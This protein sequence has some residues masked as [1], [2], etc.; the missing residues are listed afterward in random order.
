M[1]AP[2]CVVVP[3]SGADPA[4]SDAL[5]CYLAV[6]VT[7]PLAPATLRAIRADLGGFRAWWEQTHPSFDPTH[8]ARRDLL[9][10]RSERQT[11]G[12]AAPATINRGLSSLRGFCAWA[13]SVGRM[14]ED[15]TRGLEDVPSDPPAPRSL[16]T[17]AVDALLRAAHG[18]RDPAL[19][20]R[21]EAL[22]AVLV[23]AGLRAQEACDLQVRDLDLDGGTLTIRRGKGGKPRRVPLHPDAQH[24][25]QRYMTDVRCPDGP[26]LL[27][28]EA[29][30]TPLLVGR[31][32]TLPGQPLQPGIAT[33]VVRQRVGILGSQAEASGFSTRPTGR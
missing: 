3:P 11:G 10:W 15:P 24:L 30:R 2:P 28:D 21:D 5:T 29:E 33:R 25:L 18:V 16:P 4:A 6:V 1:A 26:P 20:A 14:P 32:V 17:E 31:R 7:R 12:G 9:A 19:R 22:L 23:Y 13:T 27:A 8:V